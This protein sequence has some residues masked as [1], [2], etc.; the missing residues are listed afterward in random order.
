MLFGLLTS[1]Y[2]VILTIDSNFQVVSSLLLEFK[3]MFWE[4]EITFPNVSLL[5]LHLKALSQ[6]YI[7]CASNVEQCF[8]FTISLYDTLYLMT[9]CFSH[10]KSILLNIAA[11]LCFVCSEMCFAKAQ[12][13]PRD[14]LYYIYFVNTT[15]IVFNFLRRAKLISSLF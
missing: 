11:K 3:I 7:T 1:P 13:V 15:F 6:C 2:N 4:A 5:W 9:L 12:F 8:T 14:V 10:L